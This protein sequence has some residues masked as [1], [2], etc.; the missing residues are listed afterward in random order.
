[1]R[2]LHAAD[3]HLDSPFAGWMQYEGAPVQALRGATRKAFAALIQLALAERVDF[4]ILAGDLY[5]G[6]WPDYNTG[7]FFRQPCPR[8]GTSWHSGRATYRQP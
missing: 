2:F 8:A 6:D 7:L 3:V 4:V 5:D 1:M